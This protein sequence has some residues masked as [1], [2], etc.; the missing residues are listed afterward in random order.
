[1]ALHRVQPV[2]VGQPRRESVVHLS[3][4]IPVLLRSFL[5]DAIVTSLQDPRSPWSDACGR[6]T[7]TRTPTACSAL[8]VDLP[9]AADEGVDEGVGHAV[10]H[11]TEHGLQ[12]LARERVAQ[13]ELDLAR[14]RLAARAAE[15]V[16]PPVAVE[17]RERP[18][19][20]LDEHLL[21]GPVHV[22]RREGVAHARIGQAQPRGHAFVVMLDHLGA[23]APGQELRVVLDRRHQVVHLAWRVPQQDGLLDVLHTMNRF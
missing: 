12:R 6:S 14:L 8:T 9:R 23:L 18:V 22:A 11:R 17:Q 5:A 19:D 3:A 4:D 20:Q 1:M 7:P 15:R 21:A 10:E 2:G 16:E 13:V